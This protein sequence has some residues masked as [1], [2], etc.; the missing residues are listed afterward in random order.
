MPSAKPNKGINDLK[1]LHPLIA[2]EA[3]GWDPSTVK[4]GSNKKRLWKCKLNHIWE[5]DPYNRTGRDKTGCPYCANKKLLSGFNDLQT[6]Y[7]KIAKEANG[8]DPSKIFPGNMDPMPWKCEEKHTWEVSPNSRTNFDNGCPYCGN[9][10]LLKGFNDLKTLF[11]EI[12]KEADGWDPSKVVKG[13]SKVLSWKCIKGH[14]WKATGANRTTNETG[15]P[16]CCEKGFNPG[17]PAWLYLLERKNEQQIGITNYKEDRL[18][19][20]SYYGWTEI[21]ITGP[22]DGQLVQDVEAILKNG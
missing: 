4:P 14:K 1:T 2:K 10:K 7:P 9:K 21:E 22:H 11:P 19:Y 17:K 15:C 3:F 12:A 13:T 18:K 5:A 8:W 20:H 6:R 16:E